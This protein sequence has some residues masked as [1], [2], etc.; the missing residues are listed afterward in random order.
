MKHL[1]KFNEN[2]KSLEIEFVEYAKLCFADAIDIYGCHV[3]MNNWDDWEDK[4]IFIGKNIGNSWGKKGI[5]IIFPY[6][7][8]D[9][10]IEEDVIEF[11]SEDSLSGFFQSYAKY[12]DF[13]SEGLNKLKIKYRFNYSIRIERYLSIDIQNIQ[14]K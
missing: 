7:R 5:D 12:I 14:E 3:D 9:F 2:I 4:N 8:T 6:V 10:N 11:N 1:N 13:I